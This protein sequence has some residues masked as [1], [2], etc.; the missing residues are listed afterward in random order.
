MEA[1]FWKSPS[2]SLA[3]ATL[4]PPKLSISSQILALDEETEWLTLVFGKP[5]V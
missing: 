1:A 5:V 2:M 3:E 4:N